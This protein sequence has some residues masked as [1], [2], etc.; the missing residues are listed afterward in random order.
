MSN[1]PIDLKCIDIY[2]FRAP[3]EQPVVTSFGVLR[4]RPS[5]LVRLE[6]GDGAWGWGETWCN[7]PACGAEHRA[8]LVETV[9]VP[10]L[11]D[12]T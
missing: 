8:R 3:I 4:D 6:D 7:F 1:V 2:V 11:L 9:L 12:K 5:L 10:L